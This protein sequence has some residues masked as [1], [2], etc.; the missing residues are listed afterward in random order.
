M[1]KFKKLELNDDL[2]SMLISAIRYAIGR[3]TYIVDWTVS[4]IIPLL[5]DFSNKN[6]IVVWEDLERAFRDPANL[7]DL[8]DIKDWGSL[9][10][11][12]KKELSK[13]EKELTERNS[14]EPEIFYKKI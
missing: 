12:V 6:L 8:C 7:G 14:H 2:Q 10:D 1:R 11:A 3:R 13:R 5:P 4:Y 9:H